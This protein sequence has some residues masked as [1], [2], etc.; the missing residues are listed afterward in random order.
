MKGINRLAPGQE[1][2][3][4]KEHYESLHWW[5]RFKLNLMGIL[6]VERKS[7]EENDPN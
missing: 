2:E 7:E 6:V 3:M 1:I 5:V 4:T